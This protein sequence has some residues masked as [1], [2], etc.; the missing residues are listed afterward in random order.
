MELNEDFKKV[1]TKMT[2]NSKLINVNDYYIFILHGIIFLH[3][4]GNMDFRRL[5]Q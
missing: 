3:T 4:S 1:E 2:N 5:F